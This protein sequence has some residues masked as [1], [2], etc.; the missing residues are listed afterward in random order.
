MD[1]L[2]KDTIVL[3]LMKYAFLT[4]VRPYLHCAETLYDQIKKGK[5]TIEYRKMTRYWIKRLCSRVPWKTDHRRSRDMTSTLKVHHVWFVE[6]YP[7]NSLPRLEA[8][9]ISLRYNP[10][11]LGQL[12]IHFANVKE[13][14]C[15]GMLRSDVS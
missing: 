11:G 5:K 3:H 13:V 2:L 10:Y 9:I 8:E 4:P 12:E 7:K 15:L 14:T 1:D 6:G